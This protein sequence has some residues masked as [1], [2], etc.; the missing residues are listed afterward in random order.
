MF[1]NTFATGRVFM[2]L[3]LSTGENNDVN[4]RQR[5][6][7]IAFDMT[8]IHVSGNQ[9]QNLKW[10]EFTS[11]AANVFSGIQRICSNLFMK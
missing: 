11:A 5:Q 8:W 2:F 6:P 9:E 1:I 3:I 4:A 7:G 10:R